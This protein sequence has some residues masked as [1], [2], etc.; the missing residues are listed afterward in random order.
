MKKSTCNI[1]KQNG[2]TLVE[3]MVALTISM[4]VLAGV[5]ELY[6]S[7]K[8]SYQLH[9]SVARIQEQGRFAM[10]FL[11]KELRLAG[12]MGCMSNKVKFT[13]NV[14]PSKYPSEVIAAADLV[15][16]SSN[17]GLA[18]SSIQAFNNVTTLPTT[19]LNLGLSIG[20]GE[21]EMITNTD[22]ILVRRSAYCPGGQ[23]V[24]PLMG[25]QS[26]NIKIADASCPAGCCINKNDLVVIS[27][28]Q[29]ADLFAVG[30]NASASGGSH[31]TL[32]HSNALN[33]SNTLSIKYGLDAR[34]YKF[35]AS[36]WYIGNGASGTP[37]LFKKALSGNTLTTQEMV[38]DIENMQLLFG[39]DKTASGDAN[40]YVPADQLVNS[41]NVVAIKA[42]FLVSSNKDAITT[43]P[44]SVYYN[45]TIINSGEGSDR[46][47]RRVFNATIALRNRL[48]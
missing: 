6:I 30:N 36:I 19:L 4:T 11:K 14:D 25:S 17:N 46:R 34:V 42:S 10:V 32:T 28:C 26:A 23:V 33:T 2:F 22:V 24:A 16:K 39:Q 41:A 35:Q 47:L 1:T 5:M 12:Y 13:N 43:K 40:H 45:G 48:K 37:A 18:G 44:R 31:D 7:N 3:I 9:E 21:G 29:N 38:P 15:V 27:N 20:S 8:K